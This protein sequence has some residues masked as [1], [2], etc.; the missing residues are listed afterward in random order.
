MLSMILMVKKLLEHS[1]KTNCKRQIKKNLEQKKV[2][3]KKGNK[4]YVKWKDKIVHSIVGS[5]KKT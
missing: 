3:K 2:I 4:L 5:M 1:M